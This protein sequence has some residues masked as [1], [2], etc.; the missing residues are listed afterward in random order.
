MKASQLHKHTCGEA[1]INSSPWQHTREGRE[2]G[3]DLVPGTC[4][5]NRMTR[6]TSTVVKHSISHFPFRAL[7]WGT[8]PVDRNRAQFPKSNCEEIYV[9]SGHSRKYDKAWRVSEFIEYSKI[10]ISKRRMECELQCL[11]SG[12][13]TSNVCNLTTYFQGELHLHLPFSPHSPQSPSD[14]PW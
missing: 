7:F 8:F 14:L 10:H 5:P 11:L 6:H 4:L 3:W 2:W 9:T 1:A 12:T 13:H